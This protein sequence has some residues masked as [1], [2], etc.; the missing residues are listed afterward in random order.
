MSDWTKFAE[1]VNA[2]GLE[3][4]SAD[5]LKRPDFCVAQISKHGYSVSLTWTPTAYV[6][7]MRDLNGRPLSPPEELLMG[8]GFWTYQLLGGRY[9]S[10]GAHECPT[11][12]ALEVC[13]ATALLNVLRMEKKY[14]PAQPWDRWRPS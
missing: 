13:A 7:R 4:Y 1:E 9:G 14:G 3:T 2:L 11:A 10:R 12:P 6:K 5:D 8:D